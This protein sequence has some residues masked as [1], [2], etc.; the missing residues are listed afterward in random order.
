MHWSL[1]LL[2][3]IVLLALPAFR[4]CI[5]MKKGS[6][7]IPNFS[8][9]SFSQNCVNKMNLK[10]NFLVTGEMTQQLRTLAALPEDLGLIT[11]TYMV[12]HNCL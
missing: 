1:L 4:V 11:R 10:L 7:Q 3:F 5:D 12:A 2:K 6:S 8:L 9:V